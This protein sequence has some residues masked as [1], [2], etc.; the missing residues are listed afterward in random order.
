[1]TDVQDRKARTVRRAVERPTWRLLALVGALVAG[2][3]SYALATEPAH[4]TTIASDALDGGT[5]ATTSTLPAATVTPLSGGMTR[6]MPTH[7]TPATHDDG[8][9][10]R[11]QLLLA[12][13]ATGAVELPTGHVDLLAPQ[14]IEGELV[15]T[16]KDDTRLHDPGIV[17]RNPADVTVRVLEQAR[18][19]IPDGLDFLGTAG[20]PVWI[21]PQTQDPALTWPGWSS[22][23]A[24]LFG[25]L[26]GPVT[27][28]LI[29]VSGPGRFVLFQSVGLG[30]T[31][32]I[33]STV[34]GLPASWTEPVPAHV[35]ASWAFGAPGIYTLTFEASASLSGGGTVSTGAV[36]FRFVVDG[37]LPDDPDGEGARGDPD[38]S[39]DGAAGGN[40]NG[41]GTATG[42]GDGEAALADTG[43]EDAGALAAATVAMLLLG[44]A[45]VGQ[46]R[47][48]PAGAGRAAP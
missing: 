46:P 23:H 34:D 44:L 29:D 45:L 1:M 17:L 48:R 9:G 15:M 26:D 38:T 43:I 42:A 10:A 22:E 21:L 18:Q 20:D 39:G 36:P 40:G 12:A 4:A 11:P 30:S 7:A 28:R 24:S 25:Q 47:R 31:R 32:V 35:H 8:A 6:P 14:L 3:V 37:D 19:A 13:D 33:A 41:T 5:S 16:V 2:L 27:F